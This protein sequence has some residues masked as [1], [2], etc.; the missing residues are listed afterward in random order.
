MKLPESTE[1]ALHCTTALAQL[2]DD[3]ASTARLAEHFALPVPYLSKQLA[4]LVRAGILSA[5][6]G[7]RGGFRL[8]RSASQITV[9]DVVEAI[10]GGADPYICREIRQ[11]GRGA[12]PARDCREPCILAT[13]MRDAHEAWRASLDAVTIAD[14][15]SSL[16]TE[17]TERTSRLLGG[18][19]RAE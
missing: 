5:T 16:P 1:W 2:P 17:I 9:L 4:R 8:G 6:T 7:P 11:Q 10:G 15:I 3:A 14:L 19:S 13:T 18:G 12:L